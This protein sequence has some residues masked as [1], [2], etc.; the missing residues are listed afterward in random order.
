[1]AVLPP[2]L[3]IWYSLVEEPMYQLRYVLYALIGAAWLVGL[4]LDGLLSL[5]GSLTRLLIRLLARGLARSPLAR[6]P[7]AQRGRLRG[8]AGTG[9]ASGTDGAGR[10]NQPSQLSRLSRLS[11]L[12]SA[13][14][15]SLGLALGALVIALI[16]VPSWS[17]QTQMRTVDGHGDS[18]LR[19]ARVV[20]DNARPGDGVLFLPTSDRYVELAYPTYFRDTTDL[21]LAKSPAQADNLYGVDHPLS[22]LPAYLKGYDRVWVMWNRGKDNTYQLD[23]LDHIRKDGY[24]LQDSWEL[25]ASELVLLYV[26]SS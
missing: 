20:R 1:L 24:K 26:K 22:E 3:L 15:A 10:L 25:R 5:A 6:S 2:T 23:G 8:A 16:A 19:M 7:L 13:L 11:R 14:Y 12:S 4:G 17:Q 9:G 18:Q 21:L